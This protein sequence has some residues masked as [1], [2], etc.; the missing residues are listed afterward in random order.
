[1]PFPYEFSKPSG[2]YDFFSQT[3]NVL[4]NSLILTAGAVGLAVISNFALKA[5]GFSGLAST[6]VKAIPI[7]IGAIGVLGI[8]AGLIGG[9]F[10]LYMVTSIAKSLRGR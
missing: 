2:Q 5:L 8:T 6:I 10:L 1:M 9:A 7:T 4:G 3:I